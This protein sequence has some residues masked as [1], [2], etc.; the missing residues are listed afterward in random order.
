MVDA[1]KEKKKELYANL[2]SR[3]MLLYWLHVKVLYSKQVKQIRLLP[4]MSSIP[5]Q[6]TRKMIKVNERIYKEV[7]ERLSFFL[8]DVLK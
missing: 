1:V 3:N 6:D 2:T 5:R 8:S 7:D 4:F